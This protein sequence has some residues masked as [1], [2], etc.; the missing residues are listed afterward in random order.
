MLNWLTQLKISRI[1]TLDKWS[2][3]GFVEVAT[4]DDFFSVGYKGVL[5]QA[6]DVQGIICPIPKDKLPDAGALT[7]YY[8]SIRSHPNFHASTIPSFFQSGDTADRL[9]FYRELHKPSEGQLPEGLT[10][11]ENLLCSAFEKALDTKHEFAIY[12][13]NSNFHREP[14][15]HAPT[16]V[17]SLDGATTIMFA[18]N[19][20]GELVGKKSLPDHSIA[21]F[22][23]THAAPDSKSPRM[24]IICSL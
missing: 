18:E 8:N 6:T 16:G 23:G 2:D 22:L 4:P 19:A 13:V 5:G 17:A 14:K 11:I 12:Q 3:L 24:N 20:S 1:P 21:I 7:S 9:S 15:K 10:V